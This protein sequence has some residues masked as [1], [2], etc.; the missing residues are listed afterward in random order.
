MSVTCGPVY[1]TGDLAGEKNYVGA[2]ITETE[3][4]IQCLGAK[5]DD[6]VVFSHSVYKKYRDRLRGYPFFRHGAV[7]DKHGDLHR[8]YIFEYNE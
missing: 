8:V 4:L 1:I 3:R 6:L 7:A 2:A 5:Q